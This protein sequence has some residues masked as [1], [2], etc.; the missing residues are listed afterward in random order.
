MK[1]GMVSKPKCS[2]TEGIKKDLSKNGVHVK[3]KARQLKLKLVTGFSEGKHYKSQRG[4]GR[5]KQVPVG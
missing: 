3:R 4:G 1:Y 5:K 2:H